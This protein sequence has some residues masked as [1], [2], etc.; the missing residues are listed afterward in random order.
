M[1]IFHNP[2]CRK[3]RETLALIESKGIEPEII[4]YLEDRPTK[5]ELKSIIEMLNI[6]AESLIRKGES[7]YKTLYKGKK[8]SEPKWI[9]AM[10]DHPKLMERPIVI[11]GDLAII[12]RP[13]ENVLEL[14]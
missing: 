4:L 7:I 3:S 2:R 1:K 6:D 8:L 12:G 13:P 9:Q 14:L 11:K 5:Q 10:I